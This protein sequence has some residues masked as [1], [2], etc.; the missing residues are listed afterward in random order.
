MAI[1]FLS[2]CKRLLR[3]LVGRVPQ[4]QSPS[5]LDAA[6]DSFIRHN[7][8][9]W[10]DTSSS[11]LTG[12]V[13]F[14]F[15]PMEPS[16]VAYS[17]FANVLSKK[18]DARIKSYIFNEG[19]VIDQSLQQLY[20]SFN[21]H[22]FSCALDTKQEDEAVA[23]YKTVYS[24][25][26]NKKDVFDLEIMDVH[27][28]DLIYDYH[29]RTYKVPTINLN[30]RDFQDSLKLGLS[31][32]IF[33][34]DYLKNHNVKAINV[35]HCSYLVAIPLRIAINYGIAAYQCNAHGCYRL[36]ARRLWAYMEFYD[37]PSRFRELSSDQRRAMLEFAKEN[38]AR[39]FDGEV[40][41]DMHYST[42]SAFGSHRVPNVIR[43]SE[44][45]KI[46]VAA[47]CFFDSPNGLG[48]NLFTDFYEWLVFLGEVSEKTDYDWYIKTHPDALPGN[49]PVL[50]E[51][52][53]KYPK[54]SLIPKEVS[55]H[56]LIEQGIDVALTVYG[57]IGFEY[58]ALGKLV[59]NASECNPH[60]A[61]NFNLHPKTLKEYESI[62]MDLENQEIDISINQVYEYYGMKNTSDGVNNWLFKKY[63]EMWTNI[64]YQEHFSPISYRYFLDQFRR[65]DHDK[66]V[67]LL[68]KFT[69]SGDFVMTADHE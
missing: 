47:H 22:V 11:A 63:K 39:R 50:K 33:W 44:K 46:L 61:Y 58:A 17:Y 20:E 54:F 28:G 4:P 67:E 65:D 7:K 66:R 27:I 23:L 30:D 60:V 62:L 25:L 34:R 38:I 40:G 5:E 3:T 32:Y 24:E 52:S 19:Y 64:G 10:P 35:T 56:Q 53:D 37:Y 26:K 43:P 21:A 48:R 42:K 59:I 41:V 14:E 31:H 36:S 13:L 8:I 16:I 51:L 9:Y 1:R 55:H 57:T 68:E 12:E 29:L 2:L 45:I 18:H 69:A 49:A 6:T 15:T